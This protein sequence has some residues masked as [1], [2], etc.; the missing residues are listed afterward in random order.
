MRPT[1]TARVLPAQPGTEEHATLTRAAAQWRKA[2][3]DTLNDQAMCENAARELE[4]L[5]DRGET[6]HLNKRIG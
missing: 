4:I 2:G 1:T 6:I 5:R 3:L